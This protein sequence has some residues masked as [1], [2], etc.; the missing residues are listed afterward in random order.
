MRRARRV[1]LV[2]VTLLIGFV[3]QHAIVRGTTPHPPQSLR[4]LPL[5]IGPWQGVTDALPPDILAALRPD[6]YV[7][8][9]YR[10][11]D[12]GP[13]SVPVGV[14]I[15]YYGHQHLNERVHSPSACLPQGGWFPIEVA[16][17][18]IVIP[19]A[20]PQRIEVNRYLVQ[21]EADRAVVLY[22]FQGRGRTVASDVRATFLVAY[23]TMRGR[24]SD[25]MLVRISAPV[26][27]S[28]RDTLAREIRFIQRFYPQLRHALMSG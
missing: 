16:Q 24:G 18:Q 15:A 3:Y 9:W 28:P 8:R 19:G 22:W 20:S 17:E 5:V 13:G 12:E 27:G 21:R 6:D 4:A 7:L 10:A 14:Y 23:D 11:L 1:S 25:E 26:R 2:L